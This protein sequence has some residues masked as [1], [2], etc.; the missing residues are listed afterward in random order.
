MRLWEVEQAKRVEKRRRRKTQK[1]TTQL[2]ISSILLVQHLAP[3]MVK[4]VQVEAVANGCLPLGDQKSRVGAGVRVAKQRPCR[5][6]LHLKSTSRETPRIHSLPKVTPAS[7]FESP[8]QTWPVL[9]SLS[10]GTMSH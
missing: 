1:S 10:K 8:W 3:Q 7:A 6:S 2:S 9:H 5:Q 4:E